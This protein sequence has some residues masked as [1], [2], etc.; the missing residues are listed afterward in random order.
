MKEYEHN[1][2]TE[3]EENGALYVEQLNFDNFEN[4]EDS[5]V[6]DHLE[7]TNKALERKKIK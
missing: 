2:L 7:K 6:E 4:Y 5:W 1:Y 3:E